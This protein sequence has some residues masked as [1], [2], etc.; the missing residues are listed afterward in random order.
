M[1]GDVLYQSLV[2]AGFKGDALK[3]AWGIG[4]RES[5]GNPKAYNPNRGTG[6]NSYGLFQINMLGDMGPSRRKAFGIQRNEDLFDPMV[7]AKAA[8]QMSK[9]GTDFG[10]WGIGPNAYRKMPALN[11]EGYPG[12]QAQAMSAQAAQNITVQSAAPV[13]PYAVGNFTGAAGQLATN[14][15]Q[16]NKVAKLNSLLA[17]AAP[18][19]STQSILQNIGGTAGRVAQHIADNP[20]A[21]TPPKP[22]IVGQLNDNVSVAIDHGGKPAPGVI[23]IIAEAK[24]WLGTP[25]SFG[26]G[27]NKGPTVGRTGKGFDCSGFIKYLMAKEY[28]VDLPHLASAQ[29]RIGV[30]VKMDDLRPGDAVFFGTKGKEH[31]EGLYVG[32][33]QFI[34]APHTGDVVKISNLSDPYYTK[35]FAGGRR[36]GA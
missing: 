24:S 35:Q 9:G 32:N 12:Q 17:Q 23:P 34:H 29:A 33:G 20:I 4:T 11:F 6:D 5:G 28:N 26:A 14:Q 18:S 10:A 16:I 15:D 8:Y 27:D 30:A 13:D 36:Y 19:E 3:T 2:N 25:Y 1:A 31:H 22:M 21:I 7:S